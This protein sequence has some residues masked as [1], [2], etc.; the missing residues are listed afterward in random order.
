MDIATKK[1]YCVSRFCSRLH[2][3]RYLYAPAKVRSLKTAS[4][5]HRRRS[6]LPPISSAKL[7]DVAEGRSKTGT[8]RSRRPPKPTSKKGRVE[9][10]EEVTSTSELG[11]RRRAPEPIV[12]SAVS[13]ETMLLYKDGES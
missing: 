1:L 4:E 11:K 10:K 3:Q 9:L 5:G 13:A 7:G 2:L 8:R 6:K 12:W